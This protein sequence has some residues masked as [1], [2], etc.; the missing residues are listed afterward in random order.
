VTAP[1]HL[2]MSI[3]EDA[4]RAF[5]LA[6]RWFGA[7]SREIA[8]FQVVAAPVVRTEEP[9][10]A[11]AIVE[12]RFHPGTHELYQVP[13]GFRREWKDGIAEVE[14]WVAYDALADPE[15]ARELV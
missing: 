3:P 2:A 7:K 1:H 12:I 10:L 15:L 9:L 4:L 5:V 6:Q 8:H 11:L 13:L 14:G